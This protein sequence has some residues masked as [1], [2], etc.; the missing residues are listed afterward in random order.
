MVNLTS[1]FQNKITSS[2]LLCNQLRLVNFTFI[3]Y[4]F[5]DS[6]L[7][8]NVLHEVVFYK[9]KFNKVKSPKQSTEP[10]DEN[11]IQNKHTT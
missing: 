2:F 6:K 4:V 9:R 7:S 11:T 3:I 1:T 5:E 10:D 8:S